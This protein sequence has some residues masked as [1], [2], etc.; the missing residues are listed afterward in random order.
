MSYDSPSMKLMK[1]VGQLKSMD[2]KE[3]GL[4]YVSRGFTPFLIIGFVSH[5]HGLLL[6][7]VQGIYEI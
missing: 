4:A 6:L 5:T 7:Y 3:F 2:K 1:N